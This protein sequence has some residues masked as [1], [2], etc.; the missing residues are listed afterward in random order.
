MIL[1]PKHGFTQATDENSGDENTCCQIFQYYLSLISMAQVLGD[2]Q[3][4]IVLL[5]WENVSGT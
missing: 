1:E 3:S 4:K 2:L 5:S